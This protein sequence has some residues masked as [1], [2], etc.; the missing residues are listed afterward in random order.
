[1][2]ECAHDKIATKTERSP[3]SQF[4]SLICK[5]GKISGGKI[6]EGHDIYVPQKNI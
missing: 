3:A 5:D 6:Y 4:A 2:M 1:M